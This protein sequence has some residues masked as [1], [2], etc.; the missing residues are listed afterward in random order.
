MAFPFRPADDADPEGQ[1]LPAG[2]DQ[3]LAAML[4]PVLAGRAPA[5]WRTGSNSWASGPF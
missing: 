2:A 4:R 1:S 5:A 3:D